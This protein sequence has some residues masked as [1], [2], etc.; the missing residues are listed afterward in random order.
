M[1]D[2]ADVL[3][4]YR[5]LLVAQIR[6]QTQYRLSFAVDLALNATI[7]VIDVFV[8]LAVFRVTPELAGF[9][10]IETLLIAG[11]AQVAFQ[12][13]DLA[14]GNLERVPFYLRTGLLDAVLLRP[15][16]AF[17][18]L[19]VL[20]FMPRRVGRV[21]QGA[22]TY[23]VALVL[24]GID[25]T[26]PRVLLAIVAPIAGA[27]CYGAIFT[28]GAATMFWL[29]EGGEVVNAFTYGG[30]DFASY[31]TPV[32]GPW[33]GR[34][35]GF[36]LGLAFV[37]YLPALALLGRADPLGTPGWLH[38]CTPVV[39]VVWALVAA[40]AWRVGVRHYQSTGS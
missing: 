23:G 29:V 9:G 36:V 26:V 22:V 10:L 28:A 2:V 37:G 13:A 4:P 27:V 24:S 25:W 31:P 6:S 21:V 18:Q 12:L 16:S 40:S 34:L 3:A 14:V 8:L 5:R 15:L 17:G 7:T 33:F 11:L 35:L 39:S 1:A 30:R 20:D 38:W 32:Y 19:V